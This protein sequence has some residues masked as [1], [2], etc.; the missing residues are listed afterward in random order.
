MI[1]KLM[2]EGV[3]RGGEVTLELMERGTGER[4]VERWRDR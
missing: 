3:K 2:E 4:T 1:K